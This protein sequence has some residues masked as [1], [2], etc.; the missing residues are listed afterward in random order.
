LKDLNMNTRT[1]TAFANGRTLVT[2]IALA[3]G[4]LAT[5]AALPARASLA[6]VDIYDRT[7]GRVLT[8]YWHNGEP[9]VIGKPGNEYQISVRNRSHGRVLAVMSVDGVNVLSGQSASLGQGGYVLDRWSDVHVNGWRKSLDHTAA[10]YFTTLGD[11]YAGRTGRPQN[12]GVIGVALYRERAR[13]EAY[14]H[15]RNKSNEGGAYDSPVPRSEPAPRT[16]APGA[17][18]PSAESH[19]DSAGEA[20]RSSA[21]PGAPIGTGHGRV[22]ENQVTY[23]EF[24]RASHEPEQVI[25][26]RYDSHPNL[27]AQGI[28]P[29]RRV[30]HRPNAFPVGGGFVPNPR[31]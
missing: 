2:A 21:K 9:Y 18:A 28:V 14:P 5:A 11:S 25:T 16:Y 31:W 22:E 12:V 15:W 4:T 23:T 29:P 10:F 17:S 8:K 30:A 26:I 6:D 19:A 27:V 20:K 1:A 7:E 3:I 24:V 13:V